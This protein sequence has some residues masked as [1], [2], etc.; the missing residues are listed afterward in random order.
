MAIR[1]LDYLLIFVIYLCQIDD[2]LAKRDGRS[3]TAFEGLQ[4]RSQFTDVGCR[5]TLHANKWILKCE[6]IDE[7]DDRG[8]EFNREVDGRFVLP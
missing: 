4:Q 6:V 2:T 1:D 8:D 7:Q 5:D 3:R